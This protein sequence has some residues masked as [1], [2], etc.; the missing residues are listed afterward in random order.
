MKFKILHTNDIHSRFE[1]FAKI[2]TKINELRDENTIVLDAG[3]FNDFSRIELQGTDGIAGIELLDIAGYDAISIGNNETFQGIDILVNMVCKS[4][5]PFLSCNLCRSDMKAIHG[6]HSSIVLERNNLRFLIIGT[7][8]LMDEFYGLIG[9]GVRDFKKA[10]ENEIKRNIGKYDL[11]ILLSHLGL[12]EDTEIAEIVSGIDFIIDGH[13]HKLMDEPMKVKNTL[14]HMSGCYGENIGVIEFDFI[15]GLKECTGFNLNVEKLDS[16][17]DILRSLKDNKRK[18]IENLSEPL[19]SIRRDMWHDVVEENPITNLL[20]DALRDVLKCDIGIIN[21]GVING[22]I[23]R[24]KVSRKKLIEICPSP[25]NPTYIE[26]K[27][28]YIRKALEASLDTDQ[29]MQDGKGSGFRGKY[30]GRLHISGCKVEYNGMQIKRILVGDREM[31]DEAFYTAATSDFLQRGTGYES[32]KNNN[33]QKYNPEYL[34]DT[35]GE[36]L[37]KTEF[38]EK[39]FEDRWIEVDI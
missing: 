1:N 33:N 25:L 30:L 34:R 6:V 12:K 31:R 29:C 3:D 37:K 13:S 26:I 20:A 17:V 16:N 19:F 14:I 28:M 2:V 7:S 23:R 10:I 9:F 21:S 36:Y 8:P 15:Q 38:V 4:K 39:A 24:G 27:G 11:C 18:A 22:G 5:V 32:L 35:I